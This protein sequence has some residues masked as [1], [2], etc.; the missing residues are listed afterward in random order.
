MTLQLDDARYRAATE[1]ALL[2]EATAEQDALLREHEPQ[3]DDYR[4]EAALL[5][6]VARLR[7]EE[8][9]PSSGD[10]DERTLAAALAAFDAAAPPAAASPAARARRWP[11]WAGAGV[12]L[13]AAAAAI[14]LLLV[15]GPS[16]SPSSA[17]SVASRDTPVHSPPRPATAQPTLGSPSW[18]LVTGSVAAVTD[19]DPRQPLPLGVELRTTERTCARRPNADVCLSPR[20]R[21]VARNP[22]LL[23]LVE[24]RAEVRAGA[25]LD[26]TTV[27]VGEAEVIVAAHSVAVIERR[28]GGW[29]VQVDQGSLQV[30]TSQETRTL[31][32]GETLTRSL[33]P[34]P[35]APGTDPVASPNETG[36]DA[37]S[38]KPA[39]KADPAALLRQARLHWSAG[40]HDE[41]LRLY[42]RVQSSA[43]RSR[44]ARVAAVS[45]G[46]LLLERHR[47][48]AALQSFRR[49]Q[50]GRRGALAQD[51]AYGEIRALRALGKHGAADEAT[52]RF[53][54][55]YPDSAY[56]AK[57]DE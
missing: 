8:A 40:E 7:D 52:Q 17:E 16:P 10:E 50:K 42:T 55:R 5:D 31:T 4:A 49:A 15:P 57:L 36:P 1:A 9:D 39:P 29:S 27:S 35:D 22:N 43:P 54:S 47:P 34:D 26:P 41:A 24:G 44:A 28:V 32:R 25:G 53:R 18:T 46:E 37:A 12:A 19:P 51:A 21:F 20:S 30:V 56:G 3:G 2:G 6:A 13:A 14:V 11:W 48:Q 38:P 45:A 33:E 23:A